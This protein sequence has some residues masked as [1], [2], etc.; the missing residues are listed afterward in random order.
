MIH[1]SLRAARLRLGRG[2][3]VEQIA[4]ARF[5]TVSRGCQNG[6]RGC[7][8]RLRHAQRPAARGLR[9]MAVRPKLVVKH[10]GESDMNLSRRAVIGTASAAWATT[11][12]GRPARAAADFDF[13]LGVN[14]PDSHP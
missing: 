1:L 12:L 5:R 9:R 11:M 4:T 3:L 2:L 14:T 7:E 13:K 8:G 10:Q 6:F